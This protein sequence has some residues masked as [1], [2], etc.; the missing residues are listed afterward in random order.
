MMMPR[1]PRL[2]CLAI[3]LIGFPSPT[4]AQI[5]EGSEGKLRRS[6]LLD[7]LGPPAGNAD[8]L[9]YDRLKTIHAKEIGES[10]RKKYGQTPEQLNQFLRNNPEFLK[11]RLQNFTIDDLPAK[12]RNKFADR[13]KLEKLI[14]S[15]QSMDLKDLLQN[16]REVQGQNAEPNGSETQ[17][18]SPV[19]PPP[20]AG[21]S[22]PAKSESESKAEEPG[23]S[24]TTAE[25]PEPN[26]VLSRWLLEAANRLKDEPALRNS[27]AIRD[28]IRQLSRNAEGTDE[29]WKALDKSANAIADQWAR[30]GQILPIDRLW[31]EK[32]LSWPR[33][34]IPEA[35]P[36]WPLPGSRANGG[37]R[38]PSSAVRPVTSDPA[39]SN[40]WRLLGIVAALAV[41]GII[42][43]RVLARARAEES[44]GTVNG[45]R[46][47]PWPVQPTAVKTRDELV[48]AFEYLSLL[49]LGPDARHWHHLAI[50]S[51][52]GQFATDLTTDAEPSYRWAERRQAAAQLT[53]LYE[54]ARYAPSGEPLPESAL[55]AA[56]HDLCLLAGVSTS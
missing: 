31:P 23:S 26:S 15:I 39:E 34:L 42:L 53:A 3:I 36:K 7:P 46:L 40:G 35:L 17:A 52:L 56:R 13:A 6:H 37:R 44:R 50:G 51:A 1:S 18:A 49:R 11:E 29:R 54:R 22:D 10:L 25:N 4:L 12:F 41:V 55:A 5:R 38:P 8:V 24:E 45:W 27:P 19:P 20:Q 48:R 33:S 14:Q 2:L 28:A 21:A 43:Q 30:L 32:G 47:G 16:A 9:F